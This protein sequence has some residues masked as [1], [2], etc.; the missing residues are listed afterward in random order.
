[1][2]STPGIQSTGCGICT[3][4]SVSAQS[5][6]ETLRQYLK[7]HPPKIQRYDVATKT[8]VDAWSTGYI[9][10]IFGGPDM[11]TLDPGKG[12]YSSKGS[13]GAFA[14]FLR[15]NSLGNVIETPPRHNPYHN[16]RD[17]G[18]G[19]VIVYVWSPDQAAL[20]EW[21]KANPTT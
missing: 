3:I 2:N 1:M 17:E 6:I 14:A 11:S 7:S 12:H 20:I 16:E 4:S 15:E 19:D 9:H 18:E 10:V 8:Y 5:P 21:L 13:C